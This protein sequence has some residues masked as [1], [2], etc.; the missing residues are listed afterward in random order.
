MMEAVRNGAWAKSGGV[1]TFLDYAT[2]KDGSFF[3]TGV[4]IHQRPDAFELK[5]RVRNIRSGLGEYNNDGI[6]G[7]RN[8]YIYQVRIGGVNNVDQYG[9]FEFY[10]SKGHYFRNNKDWIVARIDVN[11]HNV[12]INSTNLGAEANRNVTLNNTAWLGDV[13]MTG[14]TWKNIPAEFDCAYLKL[15]TNNS[16]SHEYLPAIVNGEVGFYE[17]H[18]QTFHP[19]EGTAP[20]IA[21]TIKTT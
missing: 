21:G 14:M 5:I 1:I 8:N 12:Y 4:Y 17:T 18:S 16:W 11:N 3:D 19:S 7:A 9:K 6:F 20:F 10:D 2:S 13:N 15:Y